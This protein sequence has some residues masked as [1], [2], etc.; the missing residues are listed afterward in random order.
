ME[1]WLKSAVLIQKLSA[2]SRFKTYLG[3]CVVSLRKMPYQAI[4]NFSHITNKK[5]KIPTKQQY[6]GSKVGQYVLWA[7]SRNN[8]LLQFPESQNNNRDENEKKKK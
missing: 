8:S 7:V 5:Q 4:L 1:E 2:R 6:L 3:D